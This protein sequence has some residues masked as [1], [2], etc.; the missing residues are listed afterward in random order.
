[1]G[2]VSLHQPEIYFF[3]RETM[4][5]SEEEAEQAPTI[6]SA[7]GKWGF[8]TSQPFGSDQESLTSTQATNPAG[9]RKPGA[10]NDSHSDTDITEPHTLL[11][12]LGD[13]KAPECGDGPSRSGLH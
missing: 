12:R 11:T 13:G 2:I 4:W 5:E 1:M 10:G 3:F 8:I 9:R 6:P 7:M